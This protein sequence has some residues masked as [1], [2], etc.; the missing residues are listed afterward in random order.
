[1]FPGLSYVETYTCTL[2]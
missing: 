2:F 1:M